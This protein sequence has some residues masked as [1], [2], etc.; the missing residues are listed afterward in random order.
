MTDIIGDRKGKLKFDKGLAERVNREY[1]GEQPVKQ[2]PVVAPQTEEP[3]EEAKALDIIVTHRELC[4]VPRGTKWQ[5]AI[6]G[7]FI[8]LGEQNNHIYKCVYDDGT[9]DEFT[10]MNPFRYSHDAFYPYEN[11]IITRVMSFFQDVYSAHTNDGRKVHLHD[12]L[13]FAEEVCFPFKNGLVSVS[14][15]VY[16]KAVYYRDDGTHEELY[17]SWKKGGRIVDAKAWEYGIVVELEKNR[18]L[19]MADG[20][21]CESLTENC[22]R[23]ETYKKGVIIHHAH[24]ITIWNL[25]NNTQKAFSFDQHFEWMPYD[26]G[27]IMTKFNLNS[28]DTQIYS[29]TEDGKQTKLYEGEEEEIL[30]Y[31]NGVIV[32]TGQE[33]I[34]SFDDGKQDVVWKGTPMSDKY[35][36]YNN[37]IIIQNK[38]V[39]GEDKLTAMRIGRQ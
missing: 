1:G 17:S 2:M 29:Y 33:F 3:K 21:G 36:I 20:K 19:R 25:A 12:K 9:E 15:L 7:A 27:I 32:N 22:A 6:G 16:N 8:I 34:A 23:W 24:S 30:A 5:P 26:N 18:E 14:G 31:K 10:T 4:R 39:P 28:G 11:G 38:S 37:G 35:A 13:E